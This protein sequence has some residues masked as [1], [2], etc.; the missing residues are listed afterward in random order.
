MDKKIAALL[1]AAAA[2]T[3]VNSAQA[4]TAQPAEPAPVSSYRDLLEPISNALVLLREDDAR[5][6][7]APA[8]TRLAQYGYY[9]HHHHHH[10]AQY[11]P[12]PYYAPPP[13]P[14]GYYYQPGRTVQGCPPHYTRQDGVCKPYRGY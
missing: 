5:R 10:H 3:T 11:Y 8:A 1:G 2:I 13:P 14:Y 9:H 12:Q 4:M 6:A 7:N